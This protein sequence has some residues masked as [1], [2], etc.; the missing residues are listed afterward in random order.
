MCA[1]LLS[2]L[3]VNAA[4][5]LP[6]NPDP[7]KGVRLL[8]CIYD[9]AKLAE[10]DEI[11]PDSENWAVEIVPAD[12]LGG[13]MYVFTA[14]KAMDNAGVAVAIDRYGW[15]S[16]NY[17]M[18]PSVVYNG[19]RQRI[20]NREYATGL[21]VTDYN[22]KDLALTSNPIPQLSPEFG[23]K[24]RLEVN[25]SNAATPVIGYY[26]RKGKD[27]AFLFTDQ[28]IYVDGEVK[29]HAL[30]VEESPD[31][32]I[33]SFVISAPGVRERKPEF[34]GFSASP[35][36]GISVR[37]GDKI[38]IRVDKVDARCADVP[39]FI[40]KFM[41]ERKNHVTARDPRNLMPMSE[42]RERMIKNIDER[43]VVADKYEYY[44]PENADW[45]SYGW[46]G[47]LINTYPMLS[48][49]DAEHLRKVKNTFDYGLACGPV[50][51]GYFYDCTDTEGNV[52][53]RDAA[54]KV[55]KNISL[56]RKNAD[57]LYWMVKQL[58]LMRAMG[59]ADEISPAWE[60]AVRNLADAFVKTW[61]SEGTW[62]NYVDLDDGSVAVYN[63][64][65]GAMAVGGLALASA[66][67]NNPEYM[68]VAREAALRLYDSF[69]LNGFTSGGC[70]D[71]LQNADSETAA[72]F[73]T[74][75]MT[76]YELTGEEKY[77]D[78]AMDAANLCATWTVSFP[79]V[80]PA[81]TP[82]AKLGANLT[83]AVW[84]S[85]QNKHGA[86][87]FC[88]QS[89]DALFKIYRATGDRRYADLMRDIIHA[90]A[91]GIQPNGKITERLT[92]CDADS[93]GSRL[94][95]GKTGW[96]ETNGA[97]MAIEIPGIYVRT[98]KR[99][100]YVFDHVVLKEIKDRKG[101][102]SLVL[103]NPTDYDA[104]VTIVAEDAAQAAKPL[105]DNAFVNWTRKARIPAGKTVTVKI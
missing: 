51:S 98:D 25:V 45:M 78:Q 60:S 84:A 43:Y 64:T 68:A 69:A 67:F 102:I 81:D 37:P 23:S 54:S 97:L 12:S 36:R 50:Q 17:V 65:G 44:A 95:G 52:L 73:M 15:C 48:L 6:A 93:R 70:G 55:G 11:T 16:D 32:S 88:T 40:D 39:E 105:G 58:N 79:Y 14:K 21:D 103:E 76:M 1:A 91:E 29:D 33:C 41:H 74:S 96:N 47:G 31:R 5:W 104:S 87:G 71:I 62:G 82:L 9:Q 49:A 99:E 80:L 34:I 53:K 19:N 35:D 27:G 3:A 46:I 100:A 2:G 77:L 75:M 20:V 66:Y 30:I 26:D 8:G 10:C 92:Y 42:V 24:S 90:H 94:D 89:G 72:A 22:R 7:S 86:P 59:I 101:G 63:T 61:R 85:T 38:A 4:D 18:I 83:G 13:S 56:T 57:V 28:G